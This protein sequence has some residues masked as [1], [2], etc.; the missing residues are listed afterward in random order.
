MI[1]CKSGLQRGQGSHGLLL[2]NVSYWCHLQHLQMYLQII[3]CLPE[4]QWKAF[5]SVQ[6]GGATD[7][8]PR[9]R[10]STF[11]MCYVHLPQRPSIHSHSQADLLRLWSGNCRSAAA[12]TYCNKAMWCSWNYF[13]IW[14]RF[15]TSYSLINSR[16]YCL[17]IVVTIPHNIINGKISAMGK[18]PENL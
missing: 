6:C 13:C 4:Y 7:L 5:I 1:V 3:S 14:I 16:V 12:A 17:C 8:Y 2:E 10:K 15:F 11:K 18:E 9:D